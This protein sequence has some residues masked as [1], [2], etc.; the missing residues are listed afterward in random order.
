[1]KL[2]RLGIFSNIVGSESPGNIYLSAFVF[3]LIQV[4]LLLTSVL[5]AKRSYSC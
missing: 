4:L 3:S 2:I 1:M 5:L